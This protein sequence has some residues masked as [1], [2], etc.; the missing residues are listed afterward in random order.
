[1]EKS[2]AIQHAYQHCLNLAA[3]HYENFP[4][5]S[6]LLPD[7]TRRPVAAIY[8]FARRADDIA[9]EGELPPQE[10]LR[11]LEQLEAQL[12]AL[13]SGTLSSDDPVLIA[14]ADTI[15]QHALPLSLFKDLLSAFKQDVTTTRYDNIDAL[16]DYARRS[17]N[18][19]GRLMLHLTGNASDINLADSDKVCSALQLINFYQDIQQDI[20]E[21]DRL[22]IP[23]IELESYELGPED[24]RMQNQGAAMQALLQF[25]FHRAQKMLRDGAALGSR[26]HG[27]VGFEIRMI[28]AGGLCICDKLIHQDDLY[29]R[30]RLNKRDWLRILLYAL[31]KRQ[32]RHHRDTQ[33]S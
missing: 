4:V 5:A 24:I 27:R 2:Q 31:F 18:P 15:E 16:L 30:P 21:N 10:R 22:Y 9:D 26:L 29:S 20:N 19:V 28:I 33:E 32:P 14:L 25:Q 12:D 6:R 1:M 13:A 11:Q 23:L 17:A 8:A 7:K 3:S